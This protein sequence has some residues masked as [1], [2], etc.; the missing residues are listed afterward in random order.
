MM[1]A[2]AFVPV[3]NVYSVF[4]EFRAG[5]LE[6]NPD[7]LD[8]MERTYLG[9]YSHEAKTRHGKMVRIIYICIYSFIKGPTHFQF[10]FIWLKK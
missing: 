5:I 1:S 2:L 8:N 6:A 3:S 7:L 4:S 10:I 9:Y